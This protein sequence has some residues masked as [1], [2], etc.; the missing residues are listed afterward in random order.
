MKSASWIA[1]L[2]FLCSIASGHAADTAPFWGDWAGKGIYQRGAEILHCQDFRLGFRGDTHA[3]EF[4]S[5]HRDCESFHEPFA[6]LALSQR[7]ETL[8]FADLAVGNVTLNLVTVE[9]GFAGADGTP[10]AYRLRMERRGELLFYDEERV[11]EG[12]P[13]PLVRSSAILRLSQP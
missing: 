12:E 8:Y 1:P 11:K 4:V 9:Y 5:G 2:L 6:P 7:G 13:T 10:H 3:L